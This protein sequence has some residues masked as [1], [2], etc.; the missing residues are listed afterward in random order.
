LSL[1][2]L[3]YMNTAGIYIKT[4][5][6]VKAK[7]QKIAKD[8]GLSLSALMNIWL[9]QFVKTRRVNFSV[10]DYLSSVKGDSSTLFARSE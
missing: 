10:D 3:A 5:P 6:E 9:I 4:Q 1:V 8:L 2:Q 7:A